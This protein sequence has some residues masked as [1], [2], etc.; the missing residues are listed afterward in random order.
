MT[1]KEFKNLKLKEYD[2]IEMMKILEEEAE[3]EDLYVSD[4]VLPEAVEIYFDG[5]EDKVSGYIHFFVTDEIV[6]DEEKQ[7]E[8]IELAEA[9]NWNEI[10][11]NVI[12]FF[13]TVYDKDDNVI[14][15]YKDFGMS[16]EEFR[17]LA[18]RG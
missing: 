18:S 17:K 6:A 12:A 5:F 8:I 11:Y 15:E 13:V 4:D 10:D 1:T 2:F 3:I 16:D 7:E 9:G 14:I